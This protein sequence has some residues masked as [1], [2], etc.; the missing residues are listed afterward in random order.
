MPQT[1]KIAAFQLVPS[2][3][4]FGAI[5]HFIWCHPPIGR[6]PTC[7]ASVHQARLGPP[8]KASIPFGAKHRLDASLFVAG[9]NR[10]FRQYA[11]MAGTAHAT[12]NKNSSISIGAIHRLEKPTDRGFSNSC[13]FG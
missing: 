1:T 2:T 3:I 5:H 8:S 7:L 9:G 4:S 12:S 11:C 13:C 10:D 6:S